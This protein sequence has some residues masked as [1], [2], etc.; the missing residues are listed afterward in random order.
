MSKK[1][2][3]KNFKNNCPLR[4]LPL[5]Y[6]NEGGQIMSNTKLPSS[7]DFSIFDSLSTEELKRLIRQYSLSEFEEADDEAILYILEVIAQRNE[8]NTD[9][10]PPV[11]E[12][13]EN[14]VQDYLSQ[15]NPK[16]LP[17]LSDEPSTSPEKPA[18]PVIDINTHP[19]KNKNIHKS[20]PRWLKPLSYAAGIALA[21][22]LTFSGT[23]YAF[24]HDFW[25]SVATWSEET[26]GFD[27]VLTSGE[28]TGKELAKILEGYGIPKTSIPTWMPDGYEI[29]SHTAKDYSQNTEYEIQLGQDTNSIVFKIRAWNN[30]QKTV[31]HIVDNAVSPYQHNDIDFFVLQNESNITIS[32]VD[33]NFECS[34][35]GDITV[36]EAEKIIQSISEE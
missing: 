20:K 31:F 12:A 36:T 22:G 33:S 32:W 27:I 24:E 26:F 15:E 9:W 4:T 14:F 1:K 18:S 35:L 30:P 23:V 16:A 8:L 6:S 29:M 19:S 2:K 10:A 28:K 11:E 21:I 13:W 25:D 7:R 34:I 5:T 17:E 3:I